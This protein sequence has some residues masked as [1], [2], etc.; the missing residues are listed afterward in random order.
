VSAARDAE[1]ETSDAVADTFHAEQREIMAQALAG[2]P[3][4][5]RKTLKL[6]YFEGLTQSE[7]AVKL[8]TPLGTVKT[9]MRSGMIKLRELLG[10]QKKSLR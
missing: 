3:E 1:E 9:R 4:E 10:D 7:I 8:K 5:Q 6:A 2:L